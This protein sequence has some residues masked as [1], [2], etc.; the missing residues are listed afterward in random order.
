M[1]LAEARYAIL[2]LMPISDILALL[3]AERDR[4]DR[5]IELLRGTKLDATGADSRARRGGMSLAARKA[6]SE[7]MSLYWA[8]RKKSSATASKKS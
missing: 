5:A 8:K 2:R 1:F 7:R 6:Q 3:E 4:I